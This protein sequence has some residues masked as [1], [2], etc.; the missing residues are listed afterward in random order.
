MS[1]TYE[2]DGT[3]FPRNP[4]RKR[5]SR[6]AV[7]VKGTGEP[8]FSA[9]WNIE[10]SFGAMEVNGENS[11]FEAHYLN[12]GLHTAKLPHP[13]DGTLVTFTGVSFAEVNFE[14]SDVDQDFWAMNSRVKLDHINLLATGT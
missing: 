12:G 7:A 9:F 11:Y 14:F 2:I 4:L 1:G 6:R 13:F 8:I 3:L 5:W 10:L